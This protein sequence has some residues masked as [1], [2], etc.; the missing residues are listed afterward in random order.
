MAGPLTVA[1]RSKRQQQPAPL[2]PDRVARGAALVRGRRLSR[3]Q[4]HAPVVQ[5]TG[6]RAPADDT[7]GRGTALMGTAI[8]QGEDLVLAAAEQG[9]GTLLSLHHP[10][11]EAQD[12]VHGADVDPLVVQLRSCLVASQ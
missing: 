2:Q 6:Y 9:N 11:T 5:G 7:F 3:V 8:Q 10:G 1:L 12:V 4:V